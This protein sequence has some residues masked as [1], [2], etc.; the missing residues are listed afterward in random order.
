MGT[1]GS[2]KE[3]T[4]LEGLW[5]QGCHEEMQVKHLTAQAQRSER[6]RTAEHRGTRL[7][8][9]HAGREALKTFLWSVSHRCFLVWCKIKAED[10]IELRN[11]LRNTSGPSHSPLYKK[12]GVS[13]T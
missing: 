10:S 12:I 9:P 1:R 7:L 11:D 13:R 2:S 8:L 6:D 3:Q 4:A 5:G